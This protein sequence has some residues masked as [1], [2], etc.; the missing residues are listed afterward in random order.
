MVFLKNPDQHCHRRIATRRGK[1]LGS[2][3]H[4]LAL[5]MEAPTTARN[6]CIPCG[7]GCWTAKLI[8]DIRA[9]NGIEGRFYPMLR[10]AFDQPKPT[11]G[12][13]LSRREFRSLYIV[14]HDE[15]GGEHYFHQKKDSIS[16]HRVA[17]AMLCYD[18]K[19]V[20]YQPKLKKNKCIPQSQSE[21]ACPVHSEPQPSL[22]YTVGFQPP[23]KSRQKRPWKS[24]NNKRKR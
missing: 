6:G 21:A 1:W 14:N 20:C 18:T 13:Y 22:V 2:S 10:K 16:A 19:P 5:F 12:L 9:R 15:D 3:M 4:F 7:L 11:G 8:Y 23:T 24:C 17:S